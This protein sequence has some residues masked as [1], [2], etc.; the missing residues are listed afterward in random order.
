MVFL[1]MAKRM[2]CGGLDA[3]FAFAGDR[4]PEP[5][6]SVANEKLRRVAALHT[7]CLA[8]CFPRNLKLRLK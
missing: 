7:L 6:F 1:I 4:L 8:Y 5:K 3:A 2:E